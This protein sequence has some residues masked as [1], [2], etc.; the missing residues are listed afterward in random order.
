[1]WR[2]QDVE[3]VRRQLAA[4]LP[5]Y[6]SHW[7]ASTGK[8]GYSGVAVLLKVG[9]GSGS[10]TSIEFCWHPETDHLGICK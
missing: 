4:A 5:E 7:V 3:E 8:K 6:G 9:G 10:Q 1:M 2:T